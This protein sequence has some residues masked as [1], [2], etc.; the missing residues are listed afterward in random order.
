MAARD[1]EAEQQRE[2][3]ECATGD[4]GY[5]P[6]RRVAFAEVGEHIEGGDDAEKDNRPEIDGG[7][8]VNE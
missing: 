3:A 2:P 8:T 1:E 7:V 5:D 4:E 6:R